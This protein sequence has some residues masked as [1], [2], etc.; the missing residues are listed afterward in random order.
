MFLAGLMGVVLWW[1]FKQSVNVQP[2][3]AEGSIRDVHEGALARPP[4]KTALWVFFAVA[5]S[6]FALF[7]SAYAM[8]MHLGDWSPLPEPK[9]LWLNT[10]IPVATEGV[11]GAN[12][13]VCTANYR[14][15]TLRIP[16]T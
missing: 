10:G 9:L 13:R 3:L 2:W 7:V 14:L 4:A 12:R 1:L 5:T 8:R 6:L 11:M 15:G 16:F